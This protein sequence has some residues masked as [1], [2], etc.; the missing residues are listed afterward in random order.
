MDG[1]RICGVQ[2]KELV[3]H[4][5]DEFL[6][7]LKHGSRD[8]IISM[9]CS[10]NKATAQGLGIVLLSFTAIVL[11][12]VQA[13]PMICLVTLSINV[14]LY[15]LLRT[16]IGNWVQ[17]RF[18]MSLDFSNA[19]IQTIYR[20]EKKSFWEVNPVFVVKTAIS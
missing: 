19:R 5:F 14:L 11:L 2:K 13:A 17:G 3:L 8:D 10:S 4:A 9:R 15:L 1:F 6:K 20:A 7:E 16:R 12:T 18:F